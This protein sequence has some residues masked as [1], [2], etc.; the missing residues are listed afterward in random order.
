MMEPNKRTEPD[1]GTYITGITLGGFQVFDEPTHIPLGQLTFLFGPNSAGKSAVEDALVLLSGLLSP[2]YGK[3]ANYE[4]PLERHWRRTDGSD[5]GFAPLLTLGITASIPT[6]LQRVL[7]LFDEAE[8]YPLQ[9][10]AA[11]GHEVRATFLYRFNDEY[12]QGDEPIYADSQFRMGVDGEELLAVEIGERMGIR[13]EHPLMS[14]AKFT[15]AFE[16]L[17]KELPHY[18]EAGDGWVWLRSKYCRLDRGETDRELLVALAG[19]GDEAYVKPDDWGRIVSRLRPAVDAFVDAFDQAKHVAWCNASISPETVPASRTIPTREELTCLCDLSGRDSGL[20]EFGVVPDTDTKRKYH[21]LAEACWMERTGSAK[22]TLGPG[23]GLIADVNRA[24][25]DHLFM[26]RGYRIGADFRVLIGLSQLTDISFATEED[27]ANFPALV[28]MFLV[29]SEGRRYGFDE[30]GSGLGYVLPVLCSVYHPKVSVSLIQQPEL[31]LHPALQTALG[32]V[33]IEAA[34]PEHQL[35]IETHSEH[36]LL[37]VLKRIRQTNGPKPPAQELRLSPQ[38]V[39]VV[40]FDPKPDGT[41]SVKRLRISEDGEFLDRWP[42]GFFSERD[43]E[44][45]DE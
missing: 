40:Y 13:I 44:L 20:E 34:S 42:R 37:R 29:D 6:N 35:I 9:R 1:F 12:W 18:V 5:A 32:D 2:S 28:R 8:E 43:A 17:A 3:V 26:E 21:D 45:F 25:S 22:H 24:L 11:W 33:F 23:K 15:A 7:G 10:P 19:S 4:P 39:V 30:V 31:H 16:A 36:V 27:A 41:T 38:D 14:G